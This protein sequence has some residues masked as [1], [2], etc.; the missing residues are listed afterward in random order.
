M[1]ECFVY[2]WYSWRSENA[3]RSLELELHGVVS[4]YC[5]LNPGPSLRTVLLTAALSHRPGLELFM[6][7]PPPQALEL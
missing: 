6:L 5:E 7:P 4:T 1:D 3:V 2:A